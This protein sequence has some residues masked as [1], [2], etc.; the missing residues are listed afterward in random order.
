MTR[1]AILASTA[2]ALTLSACA[3]TR[4]AYETPTPVGPVQSDWTQPGLAPTPNDASGPWWSRFGDADLDALVAT[5]L[6]RNRDLAAAGLRLRQAQLQAELAGSRRAPVLSG[7][8]NASATHPFDEG[9]TRRAY[10]ATIG[11]SY[12]VDL[13]GRLAAQTDAAGWRAAA[14]EEDLAATRLSL[15]GSTVDLYFQLAY[16]NERLSLAVDNLDAARRRQALVQSRYDAGSESGLAVQEARESALAQE[17]LLSQLTQQ[18]VEARNALGLLLGSG[19][20]AALT[21]EPARVSDRTIPVPNPGAPAALLARRP[22]LRA[23]EARLR[24]ILA[25]ADATRASFYPTLALTS[26]AG[27]ASDG[28]RDLLANPVGSIAA[29]LT[30]PFLDVANQRLSNASARAGYEEARLTFRQTLITGLSEVETAL[31]LGRELAVQEGAREQALDAARR[32]EAMN[33]V[34]YRAGQIA[35]RDL[36]DS[37]DR[38]RGAEVAL[39]DNR[40]ARLSASVDLN[41]ALGGDWTVSDIRALSR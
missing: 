28:L 15:I 4:S 30:L 18:R 19:H 10:D 33:A 38:R 9:P 22:D 3:G 37:Q 26:S 21:Q 11:V 24:A 27:G 16:L 14:T 25:D 20:G 5:M 1:L 29:A 31:S 41:L 13:W 32:A 36:L 35:L 8:G 40:L 39:M 23:A 6:E 7:G 34:R 12:E 17:A 2:A